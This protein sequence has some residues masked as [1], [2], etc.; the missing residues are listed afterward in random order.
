MN[1]RWSEITISSSHKSYLITVIAVALTTIGAILVHYL[2]AISAVNVVTIYLLL[3]VVIALKLN[4]NAAIVASF[5]GALTFIFFFIPPQLTFGITDVQYIITFVGLFIVGIVIANLVAKSREQTEAI[6]QREIQT[7]ALYSMSRELLVSVET[8]E[9]VQVT[10]N[11][12]KHTLNCEVAIIL[13]YQDKPA[14][15]YYTL[16]VKLD[17][18]EREA[19]LSAIQQHHPTGSGTNYF[20]STSGYYCPLNITSDASGV[21]GIFAEKRLLKEQKGLLDAFIAQATLAIEASH[22]AI[23]ANQ[24][25]LF[26]EKEL[27]HTTILNSISHDLRTPLVSI[28]GTLSYLKDDTDN[29]NDLV[30]HKL[31]QGA[32]EEANRLN[33]LVSNLLEMSRLQA[34]SRLLKCELYDV[35]EVI[36]VARSQLRDILARRQLLINVEEGLPLISIDLTLFSL[37][38]VNLLDNAIKYSAPDTP[39]TIQAY[40]NEGIV[41][42]EVEDHGVGISEDQLPFIFDRFY[43][44]TTSITKPGSGLGLPICKGIIDLHGG[45]IQVQSHEGGSRFIISCP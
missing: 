36:S 30:R 26:H 1:S 17:D 21:I 33:R 35:F 18:L 16:N 20:S 13:E 22:L 7:S 34:G 31:V 6:K 44:A 24:S 2:L 27:L 37:V 39:I 15:E 40:Q 29:P 19:A 14:E 5:L 23:K 10:L 4:Y 12:M 28:T 8:K 3:V 42:L 9:I 43:R 41:Y 25:E 45:T 38:L 32:Y 11:H